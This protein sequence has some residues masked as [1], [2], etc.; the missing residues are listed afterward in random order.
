MPT[1]EQIRATVDAYVAAYSANDRDAF[2]AL[3]AEHGTLEDPVGTPA[4]EGV[5]AIAKF[6]DDAR[7]LADRIVLEPKQVVVAGD[8]A[9]M[10]FDINAHIGDQVM[11]LS[12]VDVMRFDADARLTSVRAFFDMSTATTAQA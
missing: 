11:V 5:T 1:P 10:V 3:W 8:E 7:A 9:A 6:W 12:A 4:H 2:V